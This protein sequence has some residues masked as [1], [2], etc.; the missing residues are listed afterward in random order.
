MGYMHEF[1]APRTPQ[2]NEII[3]RKN[4]TLQELARTLLH[5]YLL[6]KHFWS[7]A[8]NIACYVINRVS[9]RLMLKKIAYE[10][11]KGYKRNISYFRVFGSKCFVLNEFTKNTKFDPKSTEEI[12]IWY[13]MI[14]KAY[15]I[16]IPSSQIIVESV[17]VKFNECT[18]KKAEKG[19]EITDTDD[20]QANQR[21]AE[22][23]IPL[24][25][26]APIVQEE[27]VEENTLNEE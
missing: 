16:Y 21:L 25:Q 9:I 19:T 22:I 24:E 14:S 3:E 15:R 2:Q 8:V 11:W 4:R 7:E 20:E 26:S 6:P 23:D 18:N 17:N 13:S 12:F 1:S 10:L 5:E 27:N